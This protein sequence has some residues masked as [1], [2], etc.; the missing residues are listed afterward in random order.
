MFTNWQKINNGLKLH[1]K[2][3][4]PFY[5]NAIVKSFLY[6]TIKQWLYAFYKGLNSVN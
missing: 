4:M 3:K 6:T 5:M 1:S 2:L